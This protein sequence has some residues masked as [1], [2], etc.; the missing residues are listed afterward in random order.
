MPTYLQTQQGQHHVP[1]EKLIYNI[2]ELPEG[3]F[4]IPIK[5]IERYQWEYPFLSEELKC[6]KYYKAFFSRRPEY[7]KLVTYKDKIVIPQKFQ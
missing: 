6:E 1:Y 3:M 2:D 5:L 7:Y 4:T